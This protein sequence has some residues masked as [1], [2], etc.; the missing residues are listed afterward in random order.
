MA[1]LALWVRWSWRDLRERWLQVAAVALIIALGTS[2][3]VGLGSTTPWRTQSTDASYAQLNMY[4]LRAV[5]PPGSYVNARDLLRAVQTID[6]PTWVTAAEAR[7]IEPVFVN[8]PRNGDD[9]ILVRGQLIGVDITGGGPHVNG[10]HINAGRTLTAADSGQPTAIIEYHFAD[11]YDLPSQGQIALSGGVAF[12]YVGIGMLPEY[13]MITTDEGGMWAQ[14]S[15]AVIFAS[16]ETAQAFAGHPGMAND[17]VIT[18]DDAADLP[19]IRAE[20]ETALGT[21]AGVTLETRTDDAIYRLM[22]DNI[23][24]NQQVYDI[25]IILFMAGAM[26]GAFNLASRIVETQRRQ[27]GI[28]MALGLPP[29]QLAIRPL[30]VGA[31]IAIMGMFFGIILGLVIG[32]LTEIWMSGLIPLPV[33]ASL[34]QPRVFVEG[35]LIGLV[36]PFAA[37][38]YPVWRAIRVLPVDAIRTGH[39][40]AKSN[41]MSPLITSLPFGK[42]FTYMPVRNLLRAP[43]RTLLTILGVAAA[44]TTLIGL[45]GILDTALLSLHRVEDEAYQNHPDRL[46]VFLNAAYSIDSQPVQALTQVS[47]ITRSIPAIRLPGTAHHDST[48][49]PVII[50]ALD[51]ANT[52]W[53]PTVTKGSRPG[54]GSL[55]GVLISEGAAQDLN[56]SVGDTFALEHPRRNSLLAYDIART[57]VQVTGLHADP[58]RTFVFMDYSQT[59]L[60][61]L[62]GMTN[63]LHVLPDQAATPLAAKNALFESPHVASVVAARD[64]V[65]SLQKVLDE[66]IRFLS[67]VE[68]AVLA[69]AFLIAFNSTTINLSE[70]AR[71]IATMFAFG[72]PPRTVT[73]MAMLEN[74]ITGVLGTLL[75]LGLGVVLLAWFYRERMPIIIPQMRFHITV[76]PSTLV[77]SV[78]FGVVVVTITPLL[79]VRRMASMDIPATLRVME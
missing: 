73:R 28:G 61:G 26:F 23:T 49:F 29:H 21:M 41:G 53:S 69:L 30:L 7:L 6:H 68:L 10:I 34:V 19:V 40:S 33:M 39:L 25:I 57:E 72:V 42:S 76:A 13:F 46:A 62:E 14:A 8:V 79:A 12:D 66:V 22:Y 31:Q 1:K 2:V 32:K 36:L 5:L 24:M 77:L 17:L 60:L 9:D 56:V 35:A 51:L 70:R 11:H 45:V 59:G 64:T 63:L 50:E 16:L 37:T 43:R 47:D 3:Y 52:V 44:I 74:F 4:D 27:I 48:T 78:V 71:E 58:W 67:G 65:A 54:T 55:P 18:L 20:L 75:G 38:L 15:F